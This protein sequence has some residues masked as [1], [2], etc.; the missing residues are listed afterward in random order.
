MPTILRLQGNRF[1]FYSNE[2]KEPP[3][4]HVARKGNEAKFWL[5]P[6]VLS[7]ANGYP[8]HEL[9]KIERIVRT[10]RTRFLEAWNE[11]F[12]R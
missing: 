12:G 4:V 5:E 11:H 8:A 6:V 9:S 1:F 10:H 7:R 2:G 3:H